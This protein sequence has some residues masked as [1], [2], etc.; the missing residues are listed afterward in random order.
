MMLLHGTYVP[1]VYLSCLESGGIVLRKGE[2]RLT[3]R[4]VPLA[5]ERRSLGCL[6]FVP[7]IFLS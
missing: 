4:V 2:Q 5:R 1:E 7:G 3:G 6:A